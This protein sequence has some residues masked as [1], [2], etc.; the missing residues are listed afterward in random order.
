MNFVLWSSLVWTAMV[1]LLESLTRKEAADIGGFIPI[2]MSWQVRMKAYKM[3]N[4]I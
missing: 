4:A 3:F 1:W 2:C